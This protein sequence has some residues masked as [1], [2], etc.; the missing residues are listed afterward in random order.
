MLD[1]HTSNDRLAQT[2]KNL[3]KTI[4]NF[5]NLATI[6]DNIIFRTISLSHETIQYPY[7]KP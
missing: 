2:D 7:F 1:L 3:Q 5:N 4:V 6:H